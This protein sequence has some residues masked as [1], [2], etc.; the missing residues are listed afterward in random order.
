MPSAAPFSPTIPTDMLM[1]LS[2]DQYHKMIAAGVL[3]EDDPV[4]LLDGWLVRKMPKNP[5]HRIAVRRMRK[6]LERVV[7]AGWYVD[8]QEPITLD[9]S[10]PEP[11]GTVARGQTEQYPDRHPGPNDL[12]LVV[13]V[14]DSSLE[15]DRGTKK[16]LYARAAIPVYWIVNLVDRQVEVYTHPSG[17]ADQPDY[18]SRQ[19]YG[20]TDTVP[21]I[22][23]GKEVVRIAVAD[24]LP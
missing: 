8:A 20:P 7:P 9:T 6:A 21:V 19:D 23:D 17:P 5:P 14:A 2:V 12:A 10:E 11:D 3:T 4:E 16:R 22:L 15:H 24:L 18:R 13:E 1:R